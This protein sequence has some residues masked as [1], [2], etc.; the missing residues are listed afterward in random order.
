MSATVADRPR[1][2]IMVGAK[3]HASCKNYFYPS[4]LF[5]LHDAK[6]FFMLGSCFAGRRSGSQCALLANRTRGHR[7]G[8]R[9]GQRTLVVR[10]S[11]AD[12]KNLCDVRSRVFESHHICT[13]S[14]DTHN[15]IRL[16]CSR[17]GCI[18][19]YSLLPGTGRHQFYAGGSR[20]R[21]CLMAGKKR[22]TAPCATNFRPRLN[23]TVAQVGS[24]RTAKCRYF[25][26]AVRAKADAA[27]HRDPLLTSRLCGPAD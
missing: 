12:H 25:L 18:S 24:L 16:T 5:S 10:A 14:D 19:A 2:V 13:R 6:S 11:P 1:F 21:T 20:S 27:C 8:V 15:A 9:C 23:A 3:F 22:A 4:H 7:S 17:C 26:Q